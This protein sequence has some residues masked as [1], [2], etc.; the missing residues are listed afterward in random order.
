MLSQNN[1]AQN[2]EP[3]C[4][5]WKSRRKSL[6]LGK[7]PW[8]CPSLGLIYHSKCSFKSIRKKNSEI[9]LVFLTKSLSSALIP[10]NLPW[11]VSGCAS[12]TYHSKSGKESLCYISILLFSL[13]L[14]YDIIFLQFTKEVI[15]PKMIVM[16]FPE[17]DETTWTG[18]MFFYKDK[19]YKNTRL[20]RLKIQEHA[21]NITRLCEAWHFLSIK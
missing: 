2:I 3:P 14:M 1:V 13:S 5:F 6:I 12:A 8:L 18:Y 20:P 9:F 21:K 16:I 15:Q 19:W 10:L 7:R 17:I 4:L 11:K